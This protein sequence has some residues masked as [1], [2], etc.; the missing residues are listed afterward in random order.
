MGHVDAQLINEFQPPST[1]SLC[2]FRHHSSFRQHLVANTRLVFSCARQNGTQHAE[3]PN[4]ILALSFE[5][6]ARGSQPLVVGYLRQWPE[7]LKP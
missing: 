1:C 5:L 3:V 2:R 6:V 7:N 4:F